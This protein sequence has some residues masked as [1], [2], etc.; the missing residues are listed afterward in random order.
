M[1]ILYLSKKYHNILFYLV[2]TI[3]N[4]NNSFNFKNLFRTKSLN[5]KS[6]IKQ[7]EFNDNN[8]NTN[9][10]KYNDLE[11]I[12]FNTNKINKTFLSDKTLENIEETIKELAATKYR[13]P[14]D[15]NIK[16][17]NNG[18]LDDYYPQ[19]MRLMAKKQ[20]TNKSNWNKLMKYQSEIWRGCIYPSSNK[21]YASYCNQH[22]ALDNNKN[23]LYEC[24]HHF[25]FV[26]CDN[27]IH[28]IRHTANVTNKKLGELL[29]LSS[30]SY[31]NIDENMNFII[32]ENEI[33]NCRAA[34][35]TEY[36][37]KTPLILPT[38]PRDKMLGLDV[39]NAAY[40]C[41][42]IKTWGYE[43]NKSGTYWLDLGSKGKQ[44]V[45]CEMIT[46]GGGWTLF[47]NYMH[48]PDMELNIDSTVS[49]IIVN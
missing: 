30:Q 23:K 9:I 32:N 36:K 17:L 29:N 16:N 4:Y 35:I 28:I 25:C 20:I 15:K 1:K 40:S 34:C 26:C 39:N 11:Q 41:M 13:Y 14:V 37:I 12:N 18:N 44:K 2:I 21:N 8:E 47:F 46:D 31:F 48:K 22:F 24:K 38:P 10:R 49:I 19:E 5:T 6:K 43:D 7:Y 45:Y 33:N 3:I 42:D 27:L